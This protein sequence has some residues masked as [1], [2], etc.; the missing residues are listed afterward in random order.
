MTQ[1]L[2]SDDM[3][4]MPNVGLF[5]QVWQVCRCCTCL[6]GTQTPEISSA[7]LISIFSRNFRP[8]GH[9]AILEHALFFR[10]SKHGW[11]W[12]GPYGHPRRKETEIFS[13]QCSQSAQLMSFTGLTRNTLFWLGSGNDRCHCVLHFHYRDKWSSVS[14]KRTRLELLNINSQLIQ[15]NS[16]RNWAGVTRGWRRGPPSVP[17]TLLIPYAGFHPT[18]FCCCWALAFSPSRLT[19][20]S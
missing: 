16:I 7:H 9:A 10:L 1:K 20:P 13:H 4:L 19:P 17:R 18:H 8:Q 11:P 14:E 15:A 2:K 5:S 3:R 6:R 12:C